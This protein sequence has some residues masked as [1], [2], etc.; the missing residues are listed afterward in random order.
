MKFA[1]RPFQPI[2]TK[3][4]TLVLFMEK[5]KILPAMCALKHLTKSMNSWVI[6]KKLTSQNTKNVN[7][8]YKSFANFGRMSKYNTKIY[9]KSKKIQMQFL[10]KIL[11][12]IR[13]SESTYPDSSWRGQKNTNVI[14]VQDKNY[15]SSLSFILEN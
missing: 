15:N 7:F 9:I 12:S 1:K 5:L 6:L 14:L 13:K 2:M 4:N 11:H 8:F 10:W 3:T